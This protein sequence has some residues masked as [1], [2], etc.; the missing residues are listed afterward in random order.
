MQV[1]GGKLVKGDSTMG[2][3]K[4]N[5]L[6]IILSS[7]TDFGA[8]DFRKR[9]AGFRDRSTV[10]LKAAMAKSYGVG[11]AEH[12]KAFRALFSRASLQFGEGNANASLPTNER[13]MAFAK[14]PSDNGL[15]ALYFQYGRY[16]AICSTRP[17]LLPPNL[18]GLWA[19]TIQTPWN[20]DYH[21][22]INIQMNHWP[23]EAANLPMLNAPYYE[24]VK[25]MVRPGERTAKIYYKAGG[26]VAHPITN[27]WGYTSP[28]EYP[29]WGA[30]NT[31]SG[32]IC[33]DL[34]EHYAFTKNRAYLEKIYPILK[35]SAEFYLSS[36]IRESRHGWLVTSPSNSP[37][38]AFFLPNGKEAS[39]CMGPTIDNQLIRALFNHTGEAAR[40]LA[41]DSAFRMKIEKATAQLAPNQIAP[42]G[43]LM[44]WLE[45]Y[46]EVEP[47]HR[48]ISP[49]WGLFPGDEITVAGTPALAAATRAL[50]D[51]RGDQGTGWSL[52]WKVNCWARLQ[53][54]NRALTLLRLLL[55]PTFE[56]G[57][58]MV[59]GGGTYPNLFC[60]HPPYQIDGNFG[61][62]AG[63]MEMLLQSHRGFIQLLPALPDGWSSGSFRGLC[64]RG[65]AEVDAVWKDGKPLSC[66][67]RAKTSGQFIVKMPAGVRTLNAGK[68]GAVKINRQNPVENLVLNLH[69]GEEEQ[70]SFVY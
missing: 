11:K 59:D 50:L 18:Q 65:G 30:T 23:I 52:A 16:L 63:I 40:L 67:I 45:N 58:N 9:D 7:T 24:L 33:N 42:D 60:G 62:C 12:I 43:R 49:T 27:V 28:G 25:G 29:S 37:E 19:N 3:E 20:G 69:D 32:W 13:L 36:M 70:L 35:G 66:S 2:V 64:V 47:H 10:L 53:D 14:D 55:K 41:K 17:G 26:W 44:E 48:H 1:D 39:I 68:K 61:G 46:K 54:G 51:G 34:W 5:S 6:T 57:Y 8:V 31:G 22:D 56:K 4:A 15:P 21:L 38:N